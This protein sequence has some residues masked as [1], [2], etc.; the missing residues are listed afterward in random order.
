MEHPVLC[1]SLKLESQMT[2]TTHVIS[3]TQPK[4]KL[5]VRLS[6]SSQ[7]KYWLGFHGIY[8]IFIDKKK[9]YIYWFYFFWS[10]HT[11][12]SL[13]STGSLDLKS[14]QRPQTKIRVICCFEEMRS[15]GEL[16]TFKLKYYIAYNINTSEPQICL[17]IFDFWK[18]CCGAMFFICE[19]R[20]NNRIIVTVSIKTIF[21]NSIATCK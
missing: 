15:S 18:I 3:G 7:V 2:T 6:S 11:E 1:R 5:P 20:Y 10:K 12:R 9:L 8:T 13:S 16:V 14:C 19:F 4:D 17:L 21:L